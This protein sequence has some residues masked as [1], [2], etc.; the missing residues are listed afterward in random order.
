MQVR[1]TTGVSDIIIAKR[2]RACCGRRVVVVCL[3]LVLSNVSALRCRGAVVF[4]TSWAIWSACRSASSE[5][6]GEDNRAG[7]AGTG[8]AVTER[9][10]RC[11]LHFKHGSQWTLCETSADR[12][13]SLSGFRRFLFFF[14]AKAVR[15]N[16]QSDCDVPAF[17]PTTTGQCLL[18]APESI[19]FGGKMSGRVMELLDSP[20]SSFWAMSKRTQFEFSGLECIL[21]STPPCGPGTPWVSWML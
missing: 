7:E 19:D 4:Q 6:C 1:R 21:V 11:L 3:R 12:E 10:R 20:R 16:D 8:C 14:C 9:L 5:V 13:L 2:S 15:K 17:S 18:G